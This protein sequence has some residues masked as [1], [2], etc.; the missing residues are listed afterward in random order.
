MWSEEEAKMFLWHA[1]WLGA[2]IEVTLVKW[3]HFDV[4]GSVKCPLVMLDLITRE[5]KKINQVQR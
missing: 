5:E 4:L 1:G 3:R 2:G